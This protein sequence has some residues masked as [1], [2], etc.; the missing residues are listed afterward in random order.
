MPS[1]GQY[2]ASGNDFAIGLKVIHH[3]VNQDRFETVAVVVVGAVIDLAEEVIQAFEGFEWA[4]DSNSELIR[5]P[6]GCYSWLLVPH[7]EERNITF[8]QF[9]GPAMRFFAGTLVLN[10]ELGIEV[11]PWVFCKITRVSQYWTV[12][13]IC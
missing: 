3:S 2:L 1:C 9:I 6:L 4:R 13:G 7:C 8:T 10:Y 12:P 5:T 11:N